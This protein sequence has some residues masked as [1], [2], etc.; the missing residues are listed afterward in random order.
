MVT[1]KF[2]YLKSQGRGDLFMKKIPISESEQLMSRRKAAQPQRQADKIIAHLIEREIENREKALY[3][4]ALAVEKDD[5]LRKEMKA[6]DITIYDGL[7][8]SRY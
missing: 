5:D 1:D 6:W 3:E 4:C 7:D 2:N 8:E